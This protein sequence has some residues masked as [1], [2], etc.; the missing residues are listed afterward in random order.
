MCCL[1]YTSNHI[2]ICH[3]FFIILIYSGD[4]SSDDEDDDDDANNGSSLYCQKESSPFHGSSSQPS[5]HSLPLHPSSFVVRAIH[6]AV[7]NQV[8]PNNPKHNVRAIKVAPTNQVV[9]NIHQVLP[10]NVVRAMIRRYYHPNTMAVH[11]IRRSASVRQFIHKL[12]QLFRGRL[13]SVRGYSKLGILQKVLHY[14]IV[15]L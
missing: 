3:F 10:H 12:N 9:T 15:A 11:V 13:W 5:P 14:I 1:I 7:A 2:F 6:V 4:D 8:V